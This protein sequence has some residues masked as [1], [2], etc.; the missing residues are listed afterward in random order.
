MGCSGSKNDIQSKKKEEKNKKEKEKENKKISQYKKEEEDSQK[1]ESEE[2]L[3]E[4]AKEIEEMNNKEKTKEYLDKLYKS[5]YAAKTYF[6]SHDLKEKEV[7]AIQKCKAIISAKKLLDDGKFKEIKFKELPKELK[8]EYITG[9]KKEERKQEINKIMSILEKEKEEANNNLNKK[10][11]ELEKKSKLIKKAEIERFKLASKEILDKEKLKKDKIEKEIQVIKKVAQDE[12]TPIPQYIMQ[13]E[14]YKIVKENEDIPENVMRI[15]VN[16]LTYKKSNPLVVLQIKINN[17]EKTKEIKGKSKDD[18]NE[19]FDWS[20]DDKDFANIVRNKIEIALARTYIIKSNK[21]KGTSEINLRALKESDSIEGSHKIKMESGKPDNLIDVE[22][23]LRTPV[24]TKNYESAYREIFCITKVYPKF[25]IEGDNYVPKQNI[26]KESVNTILRDIESKS[27]VNK[28]PE[29]KTENEMP[30]IKEEKLDLEQNKKINNNNNINKNI[31]NKNNVKKEIKT[32]N[33]KNKNINNNNNKEKIDKSLFKEE[34]LSDPDT[35]DNL[36]SLKVLKDRL[37]KLEEKIS[38]IDGRTPR[39]LMQKKVKINIKIKNFES[40]MGE[41]EFE[42]K[43][44]LS[45]ME[46]QLKHDLILCKYFKQEN[47]IEKA[48]IVFSRINLLNEEIAEL[49]KYLQ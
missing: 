12:F 34:E 31:N 42:P 23:K 14:E 19:T 21:L 20:F 8:P 29:K 10:L 40:Q 13:Q 18:I 16:N 7:D 25:N 2:S 17:T 48:K 46:Q 37:K 5:Y 22:I 36:N 30:V 49:K 41:G 4:I 44:Y 1:E 38:K 45:L 35:I 39:E 15:T 24:V 3:D 9:F 26:L 11:E 43:D 27:K 28:I 32:N 33:E 6:C 47:E